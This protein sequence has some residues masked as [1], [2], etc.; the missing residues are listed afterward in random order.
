MPPKKLVPAALGGLFIGVLSAL[1]VVS[2]ANCCCLWIIGGGYLAAYI[3]QQDHPTA[4]S[5][6]DGALVGFLSGIIGAVVFT[7]VVI[8]VDIVMGP[9]QA[10]FLRRIL[11]TSRGMPPGLREMLQG[12]AA[13]RSSVVLASLFRFVPML[14]VSV[15]FAPIGGILAAVFSRRPPGTPSVGAALGTP[16]AP[17]V[18]GP[19]AGFIPPPPPP[20]PPPSDAWPP[21]E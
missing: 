10:Q 5:A 2:L 7:L 11:N 16:P 8:P 6:V 17:P 19:P 4:I 1:P 9:L 12:V 13:A 15:V 14:L 3:M 20:V 18:S 21:R